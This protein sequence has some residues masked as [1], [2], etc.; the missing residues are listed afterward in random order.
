VEACYSIT[1]LHNPSQGLFWR[2]PPTISPIAFRRYRFI[3]SKKSFLDPLKLLP[4]VPLLQNW[5]P[6]SRRL[7]VYGASCC[8]FLISFFSS[9]SLVQGFFVA[10]LPP[11]LSVDSLFFSGL[12]DPQ[13][14]ISPFPPSN[15]S[16]FFSF[17]IPMVFIPF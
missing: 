6:S 17:H 2:S 7:T 4:L 3:P 9:S 8:T 1:P 11:P 10:D 13:K 5:P 14:F 12:S 15:D 16:S